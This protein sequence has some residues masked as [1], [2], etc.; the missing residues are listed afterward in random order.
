MEDNFFYQTERLGLRYIGELDCD[1][2]YESW[3]N[4][5]E[6]CKYNSHHK[7][8]KS[9][10]EIKDYIREVNHSNNFLVLAIIDKKNN[11]HIGNISLQEINYI[12]RN[13]ELAF[14]IGEKEYWKKGYATEAAKLIIKHAFIE[15]NLHRLYLGTADN[16]LGMLKLA[17][18]LGFKREGLRKEA[19]FKNGTYHDI[20]E[21]GIIKGDYHYNE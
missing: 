5:I 21:Y 4:D 3:F 18:K 17:E 15:L 20:I 13:A 16:N 7:F 9:K 10:Q 12:D 19:L 14:I 2:N 11:K 1:G 8:P 6:V